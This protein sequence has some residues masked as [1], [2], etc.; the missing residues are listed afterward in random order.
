M[1]EREPD[2][3]SG[4]GR[5]GRGCCVW[6]LRLVLEKL[7]HWLHSTESNASFKNP[8]LLQFYSAFSVKS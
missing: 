4:H 7:A 3:R 8:Q 1:E 5:A 2:V 6:R